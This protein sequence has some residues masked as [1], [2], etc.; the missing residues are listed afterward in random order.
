MKRA[1]VVIVA[2]QILLINAFSVK[3]QTIKLGTVAPQG[4]PWYRIV[5]EMGE[6]WGKATG[7]KIRLRIYPGGCSLWWF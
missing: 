3:A 7:G 2:A 4:S 5:R 6:A 1:L